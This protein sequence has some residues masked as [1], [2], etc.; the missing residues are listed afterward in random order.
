MRNTLVLLSSLALAATS[1]AVQTSTAT[2][3][4]DVIYKAT[5][6]LVLSNVVGEAY[7]YFAFG[8][9][10]NPGTNLVAEI[11]NDD[12]DHPLAADPSLYTVAT[13]TG[14]ANGSHA[15]GS[16]AFS[17]TATGKA[18]FDATTARELVLDHTFGYRYFLFFDNPTGSA[19]TV[20]FTVTRGGRVQGDFDGPDYDLTTERGRYVESDAFGDAFLKDAAF[21]SDLGMAQFGDTIDDG[22][23]FDKSIGLTFTRTLTIP[24]NSTGTRVQLYASAETYLDYDMRPVPEPGTWAALGLGTLA[25]LRRRR[26]A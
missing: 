10:A 8:N 19:L 2:A 16:N 6:G 11:L 15:A 12:F 23:P 5:A 13:A 4:T 18:T 14:S 24:K 26:R 9:S 1:R 7:E 22:K 25:L 20:D 21:P 17:M 3:T